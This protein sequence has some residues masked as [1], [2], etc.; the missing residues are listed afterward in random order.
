M[1]KIA[2]ITFH[3]SYNYGS[4][5][6]AYALQEAVKQICNNNCKYE[7]INLRTDKQKYMYSI[8][9]GNN[10][11]ASLIRKIMIKNYNKNYIAKNA[12]FEEFIQNKL[13]LTKE[14]NS[15]EE[16]QKQELDYDYY[17]SGS[18]QL[19]NLRAYDFDWA[20]FLGFTTKGK[21]ISYAAS[22]GPK[23]IQFTKEEKEQIKQYIEEYKQLSVREEGSY[24]NIY[25]LTG[26]KPQINMDPTIL[27]EKKRMGKVNS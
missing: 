2:T 13:E 11:L 22:F 6:Q 27:L 16:L 10:F 1:K 15:L 23:E 21:K 4:S 3:A 26:K 18:D 14:Y 5:L 12:K 7:I 20:Y 24:N 9:K 8:K 17:I 19:W 25:Q